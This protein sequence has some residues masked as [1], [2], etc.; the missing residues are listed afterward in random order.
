MMN[1]DLSRIMDTYRGHEDRLKKRVELSNDLL[2]LIAYEQ[3]TREK[4]QLIAAQQ[5]KSMPPGGMPTIKE[6]KEDEAFD[7][8]K[9]ELAQQIGKTLQQKAAQQGRPPMMAGVAAAP[10]AQNVMPPQAMAAGGIVAFDSGGPIRAEYSEAGLPNAPEGI[11]AK[12]QALSVI[13]QMDDATVTATAAKLTGMPF[14]SPIQARVALSKMFGDTTI[15]AGMSGGSRKVSGL[16]L[17]ASMPAMGG[18]MRAGVD[19]PRGSSPAFSLGYNRQFDRGG[20]VSLQSGG[21]L[22]PEEIA[23]RLRSGTGLISLSSEVLG[24]APQSRNPQALIA[25]NERKKQ[26][27]ENVKAAQ[28]LLRQGVKPAQVAPSN[29]P[30]MNEAFEPTAVQV[31]RPQPAAAP[32]P[33]PRPSAISAEAGAG[34][35]Y[36]PET[37]LP[38]VRGEPV[39]AP[40]PQTTSEP[41]AATP[42]SITT[43]Q[44]PAS[45]IPALLQENPN[46]MNQLQGI[47]AENTVAARNKRDTP[48][49]DEV[50]KLRKQIAELKYPTTPPEITRERQADQQKLE[51]YYQRMNDPEAQRIKNLT[52]F[53]LGGA[54]RRGIGSVLG[55][56]GE[57]SARSAAAQEAA[58]LQALKDMQAGR[59]SL[60]GAQLQEQQAIFQSNL[61]KAELGGNIAKVAAEIEAQ[62]NIKDQDVNR[63]L[64]ETAL[65]SLTTY[66]SDLNKIAAD[67]QK[68]AAERGVRMSTNEAT[69]L[70]QIIVARIQAG[71]AESRA[72]EKEISDLVTEEAK[73]R[74]RLIDNRNK[75]IEK[76]IGLGS[77]LNKAPDKRSVAE[78]RLVDEFESRMQNDKTLLKGIQDRLAELR[79]RPTP[80]ASAGSTGS[81]SSQGVKVT[82]ASAPR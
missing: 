16:S 60:R 29:A 41:A 52:A 65:R 19:L 67:I 9:Q 26:F 75:E 22:S 30:A 76:N 4:R 73:L 56:A 51:E 69:N 10:G 8:T 34:A 6:Q 68:E 66:G 53:L 59:E 17:G 62:L 38:V 7:L 39:A 27:E 24:N 18:T 47:F 55:G 64:A 37:G 14:E 11:P 33:A 13:A 2:E 40:P 44:L 70:T 57:A 63:A 3:L 81:A 79:G 77:A 54:G 50:A 12:N 20:I 15:D 49:L 61:K 35:L 23:A 5:A 42:P 31:P 58:G 45:G 48:Q 78:Q 1:M 46:L 28:E 80:S 71:G 32:P 82:G 43:P 25:W 74:E 36:D 21:M 72:K